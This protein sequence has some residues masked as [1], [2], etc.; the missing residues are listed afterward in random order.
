VTH[1]LKI[2]DSTHFVAS[3]GLSAIAELLVTSPVGVVMKY[4]HICVSVGKDISRTTCAIF[5]NFSGHVAYGR[6]LVLLWQSD[7]IPMVRGSSGGFSSTLT[8]HWA[9]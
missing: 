2:A 6:G 3:R 1:P 9:A 8:M 7:K 4:E 5:T